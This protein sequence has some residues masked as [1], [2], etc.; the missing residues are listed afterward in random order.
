[1]TQ[2]QHN[3]AGNYAYSATRWHYPTTVEQLQER[4]SQGRKLRVLGS[5]HSFNDIADSPE[6]LISLEHFDH[7]EPVDPERRTVTIAGGVR[8]GQLCRQLHREGYALP[9]LASLPH[10]SVAGACA[11]ATHGSGDRNGNLATTVR[12]M[13]LVTAM[14]SL[15]PKLP[16][17]RH[18][19]Q[20]YDP[21]GKFRNAFLD[22]YI[23]GA[24]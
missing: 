11:T 4:V 1:M 22:T 23:F 19:L 16:D 18:L 6:D 3:W 8:Y 24:P 2:Q 10:I 20:T 7:I 21:Q 17:F 5:R 15:Y 9:N 14:P 12:E 13:E